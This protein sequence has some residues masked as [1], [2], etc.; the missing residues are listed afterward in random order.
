MAA[1]K[2]RKKRARK[3]SP[4]QV[5]MREHYKRYFKNYTPADEFYGQ[6]KR[7]AAGLDVYPPKKK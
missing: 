4:A 7:E 6:M 2:R 5:H 3:Y 1:K